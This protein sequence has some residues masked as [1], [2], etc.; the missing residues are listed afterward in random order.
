[1]AD[2][3]YGRTRDKDTNLDTIVRRVVAEMKADG[4]L[5][6]GGSGSSMDQTQI[7]SVVKSWLDKNA[8][9]IISSVSENG[10]LFDTWHWNLVDPSKCKYE[11]VGNTS[12]MWSDYISVIPGE[13]YEASAAYAA[14]YDSDKNLIGNTTHIISTTSAVLGGNYKVTIP[15]SGVS[16]K[17]VAYIRVGNGNSAY[18]PSQIR[19]IH[20]G[21]GR[22]GLNYTSAVPY[23]DC[24][25]LVGDEFLSNFKA[26]SSTIS[27]MDKTMLVIGDSFTAPGKWVRDVERNLHLKKVWNKAVSGGA[28]SN[29]DQ[30]SGNYNKRAITQLNEFIATGEKPDI[31]LFILGTNDHNVLIN[32]RP[33]IGQFVK[34]LNPADFNTR[35]FYGA[36]QECFLKT[37]TTFPEA[38]VLCGITPATAL[39]YEG[40]GDQSGGSFSEADFTIQGVQLINPMKDLCLR[41]GIR[42]IDSRACGYSFLVPNYVW[43]GDHNMQQSN[44]NGHPSD[45]ANHY[46]GRYVTMLL[47]SSGGF[48]PLRTEAYKS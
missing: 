31:I 20:N 7:E 1:M 37:M 17:A 26:Y 22:N 38:M 28:F 45:L 41:Y 23:S 19:F 4:T 30:E 11:R 15:L 36:V 25:P 27:Y 21:Y 12:V 24:A 29:Y 48:V 46:I 3:I 8:S 5:P 32:G 47:L 39:A 44:G 18:D 16:G 35:T 10:Y 34:S 13:T 42:Y 6:S 43:G 40:S 2:Y 9:S 33:G 14:L